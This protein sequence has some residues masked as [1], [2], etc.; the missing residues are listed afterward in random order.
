[1]DNEIE[2]FDAEIQ[3]L[4]ASGEEILLIE[5]HPDFFQKLIKASA[6]EIRDLLS[7]NSTYKDIRIA[8]S[9][10]AEGYQFHIA[11]EDGEFEWTDE[12]RQ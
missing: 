3:H 6:S 10:D 11:L 9:E 8:L 7:E 12:P 5:V 1:M 4:Q 2:A